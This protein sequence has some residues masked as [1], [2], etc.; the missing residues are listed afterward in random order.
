[1]RTRTSA[2]EP[3]RALWLIALL[4]LSG[5]AHTS[6]PAPDRS[7]AKFE[8]GFMTGMVNHHQMAV[9]MGMICLEK[10]EHHEL[11]T[12]CDQIVMA[13]T[14]EISA[15]N[16]WLRTW[17]GAGVEPEMS[18]KDQREMD[19]L[20]MLNGPE[21]EIEFM[22]SMIRHHFTAIVLSAECLLKAYHTELTGMCQDIITAQAAE[23]R[24]LR[25][26]LCEWYGICSYR[27]HAA[28]MR[29]DARTRRPED[30]RDRHRRPPT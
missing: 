19:K 22:K 16:S 13:Q 5:A 25:N 21:F 14:A 30:I 8:I 6:G 3:F 12:M 10:A 18:R 23:I 20:E 24:Q 17:Y 4:M 28:E 15:L 7:T 9:H 27:A 1:M 26:W 11:R 29:E 2:F